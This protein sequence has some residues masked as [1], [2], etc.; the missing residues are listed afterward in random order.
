MV[1]KKVFIGTSRIDSITLKLM[2][3]RLMGTVNYYN[4]KRVCIISCYASK[5]SLISVTEAPTYYNRVLNIKKWTEM[6]VINKPPQVILIRK[7]SSV[8]WELKSFK[9][10]DHFRL[11]LNQQLGVHTVKKNSR[12]YLNSSVF[13]LCATKTGLFVSYFEHQR[14]IIKIKKVQ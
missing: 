7:N 2:E 14:E 12:Q 5:A 10:E 13:T 3:V 9:L 4:Y 11:N 6:S 8:V 1:I